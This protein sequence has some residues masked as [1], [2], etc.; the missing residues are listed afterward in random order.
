MLSPV[1]FYLLLLIDWPLHDC[2]CNQGNELFR[3]LAAKQSKEYFKESEKLS[4][5]K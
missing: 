3:C 1:D 5:I 2:F 4:L